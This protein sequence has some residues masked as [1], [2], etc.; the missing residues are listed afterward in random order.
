MIGVWKIQAQLVSDIA[1]LYGKKGVLNQEQMIYCLFR[2]TA[3][4]AVRDLVVRVGERAVVKK[5]SLRALQTLA[6][7]IGY[8]VSQRAIGK[9]LSR[10]IPVAG[11]IGVGAYAYYDTAQV[12]TTAVQLFEGEIEIQDPESDVLPVGQST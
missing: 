4:Q 11:A 12:G 6:K 10:W 3:A 5:A 1:S 9:G 2:H 7:R 8:K